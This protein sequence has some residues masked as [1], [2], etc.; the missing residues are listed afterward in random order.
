MP[1]KPSGSEDEPERLLR[2][3]RYERGKSPEELLR[4]PFLSGFVRASKKVIHVMWKDLM[5]SS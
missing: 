1:I 3:T 5:R 4:V 2:D